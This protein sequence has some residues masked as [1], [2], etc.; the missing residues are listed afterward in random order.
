MLLCQDFDE[1]ICRSALADAQ[2]FIGYDRR[3]GLG[4]ARRIESAERRTQGALERREVELVEMNSE[5]KPAGVFIPPASQCTWSHLDARV[6][7]RTI[8]TYAYT[9]HR[10][11]GATSASP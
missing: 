4:K 7:P 11:Q 1:D 6:L 3:A 8:L 9:P 10:V 5:R 2:V